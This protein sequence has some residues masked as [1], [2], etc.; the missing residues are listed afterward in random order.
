MISH[1]FFFFFQ[2]YAY[3][4]RETSVCDG[5]IPFPYLAINRLFAERHWLYLNS[6]GLT[7]LTHNQSFVKSCFDF[8]SLS[9]FSFFFFFMPCTLCTVIK[10]LRI[11]GTKMQCYGTKHMGSHSGQYVF[12]KRFIIRFIIF[13][14]KF[15]E[16]ATD[17][18]VLMITSGKLE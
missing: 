8:D 1:F 11:A 4:Q 3:F 15:L 18:D 14:S 2:F 10:A 5:T 6:I 12:N 17:W 7:H 16:S 13:I 9:F